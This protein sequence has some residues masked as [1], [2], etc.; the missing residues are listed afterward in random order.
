MQPIGVNCRLLMVLPLA[1]ET[2]LRLPHI[3]TAHPATP[4]YPDKKATFCLD[5]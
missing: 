4:R 3:Q 5:G 1:T 2:A